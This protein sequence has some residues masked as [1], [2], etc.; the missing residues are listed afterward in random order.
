MIQLQ[1]QV[2][3]KVHGNYQYTDKEYEKGDELK[4][5]IVEEI[6]PTGKMNNVVIFIMLGE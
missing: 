4:R 3:I 2:Q 1:K 6:K 5:E